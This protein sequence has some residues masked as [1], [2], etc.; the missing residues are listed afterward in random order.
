MRP[1]KNPHGRELT[2]EDLDKVRNLDMSIMGVV[3]YLLA[4][5]VMP[6]NFQEFWPLI[7]R[8]DDYK[9][10]HISDPS[11]ATYEKTKWKLAWEKYIEKVPAYYNDYINNFLKFKNA[12]TLYLPNTEKVY[13]ANNKLLA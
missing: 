4:F 2:D 3:P 12:P 6:L 5:C 9:G 11:K 1:L 8:I 13:L 10:T 7:N